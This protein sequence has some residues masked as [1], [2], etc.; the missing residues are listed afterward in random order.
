MVEQQVFVFIRRLIFPHFRRT[1]VLLFSLMLGVGGLLT[2]SGLI[3]SA[4]V[5]IKLKARDLLGADIVFSSWRPLNDDWSQ[6]QKNSLTNYG[7][8]SEVL[9]LAT[10]AKATEEAAIPSLITLKGIPKSYPL[11]GQLKIKSLQVDGELGEA[12]SL[13]G[14]ELNPGELWVA[15]SLWERIKE[16]VL[17]ISGQDFKIVGVI[18]NEPDAGFAGALSFSP[19]VMMRTDTLNTL[20]LIRFGSRVRRKLLFAHQNPMALKD[21]SNLYQ[22]MAKTVP[23]HIRVQSYNNGQAN[24]SILLERVGLFFTMLALLGL[25]LC[26]LAFVFGV[27]SLINDHLKQIA[28][29]HSMGVPARNSQKAYNVFI[30]FTAFLGSILAWG[31]S[32]ALFIVS[33]PILSAKLGI[34]LQT[35]LHSQQAL[36]A[37]GLSLTLGLAVNSITQRALA[38]IDSQALWAGRADGISINRSE[39]LILSLCLFATITYYLKFSSGSWWLGLAFSVLIIALLILIYCLSSLG[40]YV[41]KSALKW[42]QA[43]P[44]PV[45]LVFAIRHLLGFKRKVWLAILSMG[46]SLSLVGSLELLSE[47]LIQALKVDDETAP[48]IFLIDIQE[49]QREIVKDIF[50]DLG[51][52]SPKLRPLIRARIA[53]INGQRITKG[54]ADG[55]SVAERFR[56][57]SLTREFNLTTQNELSD[58]E[59]IVKGSWWSKKEAQDPN[60]R[61]LSVETRF[62]QRMGLKIGDRL[63][64]DIQGRELEFTIVSER[65]VNWLSFA[66]NFIFSMPPATLAGAPTTWISASKLPQNQSLSRLSQSLYQKA[67][68]ISVIDLRPI[69]SEGR[70]LLDALTVLLKYSAWGCALAGLLLMIHIM[71]RDRERREESTRLLC[72]LGLSKAKAKRWVNI[73]MSILG[74]MI[75]GIILLGMLLLVSLGCQALNIPVYWSISHILVW[76]GI[77]IILPILLSILDRR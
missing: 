15:A 19:R 1:L 61:L 46:L 7:Q 4:Q 53:H 49:D 14:N 18:E 50:A 21:I 65:R 63:G 67:T 60:Q 44:R 33:K 2:V 36:I 73:E 52:P 23:D 11:R 58:S 56:G 6:T 57:R 74:L 24:I 16:P 40:F 59:Q 9:E 29:A 22:Q 68:N 42:S 37:L 71:I 76:L 45:G 66:P 8:V 39:G 17:S 3:E 5:S 70:Q 31:L 72:D 75:M 43:L 51:I 69:L 20:S 47:S 26:V 30:I 41:L 34:D 54:M 55:K 10:M 12:Q 77:P 64:F 13:T 38:R 48:Q 32:Q 27:W 35:S 62:A 25:M 28:I